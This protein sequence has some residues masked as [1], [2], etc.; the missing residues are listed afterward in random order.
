MG[1][2]GLTGLA[3]GLTGSFASKESMESMAARCRTRNF[4]CPNA[5][6]FR[7]KRSKRLFNNHFFKHSIFQSVNLSCDIVSGYDFPIGP[8][9]FPPDAMGQAGRWAKFAPRN[10]SW[11]SSVV[12]RNGTTLHPSD[13]IVSFKFI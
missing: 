1:L 10:W 5:A 2:T 12:Q 3:A 9:G 13:L 6:E 4:G 8:F 7:A 11:N